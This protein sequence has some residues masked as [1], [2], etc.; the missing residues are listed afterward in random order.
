M[1]VRPRVKWTESVYRQTFNL[2]A[3]SGIANNKKKKSEKD[4]RP[5]EIVQVKSPDPTTAVNCKDK[6]VYIAD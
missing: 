4:N 2:Q 6:V 1:P 3:P 5:S